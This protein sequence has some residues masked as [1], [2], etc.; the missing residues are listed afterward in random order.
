V[1]QKVSLKADY[2]PGHGHDAFVE[3]CDLNSVSGQCRMD[4]ADLN[5]LP[6]PT[7]TQ[8]CTFAYVDP[9]DVQPYFQM[10][11]SI[12]SPTD[13]FQTNQGPSFPAH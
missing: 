9:A 12:P 1:L 11:D 10:A 8:D 7:G 2:N 5:P 3:Q 6:C 13:M 4:G